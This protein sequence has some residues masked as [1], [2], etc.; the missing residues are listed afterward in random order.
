M[1]WSKVKKQVESLFCDSLKDRV[2]VY[3]TMYRKA[4]DQASHCWIEFDKS[5]IFEAS[6]LK[7]RVRVYR[8]AKE[9]QEANNTTDWN[10][11]SQRKG[12]YE[13]YSYAEE[14]IESQGIFDDG[15]Y[16]EALNKYISESIDA[17][18]HS[19][20]ILVRA[21]GLFDKRVGKRRLEKMSVDQFDSELEKSF[22]II[23]CQAE[24]MTII[25]NK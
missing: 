7:W 10:E 2:N 14:I 23:R 19:E 12:Y 24:G 8:L 3:M 18:L 11:P 5:T 9:I 22:Y 6:E 16:L 17:I 13:S 1:I 4:H 25:E 20:N 21:L 15:Y